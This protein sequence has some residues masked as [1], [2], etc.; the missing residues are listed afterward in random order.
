MADTYTSNLNMTKP[1]VGAS[2]DTWGTKWN[3]NLDTIDQQFTAAALA[4]KA[5]TPAADAI[6]YFTSGSAASV[7]TSH[8][9]GRAFAA[10]AS[11]AAARTYL[12]LAAVAASGSATDLTTGTLADARLP[13]IMSAKQFTD[14]ILIAGAAPLARLYESDQ[15]ADAKYWDAIAQGGQFILRTVNDALSSA[16]SFMTATRSGTTITDISFAA[17][18]LRFN[19]NAIYH[20][21]NLNPALYAPL[22]GA[23]FTG[24]VTMA[25]GLQ[26]TAGNFQ[27]GTSDGVF[28]RPDGS[29]EVSR[30]GGAYIDLKDAPGDDFD[31]RLLGSNAGLAVSAAATTFSGS[32][33]T[34]VAFLNVSTAPYNGEQETDAAAD[35][36]RWDEYVDGGTR[37]RR[38]LNDAQNSAYTFE[39]IVRS[40]V[41]ITGITWA[42]AGTIDFSTVSTFRHNGNTIWTA[43]NDGAGSG[44]DADTL[45]G[46]DSSLFARKSEGPNFTTAVPT[47]ESNPLKYA[48][49]A[50]D[51]VG[52]HALLACTTGGARGVNDTVAGSNLEWAHAGGAVSGNPSG[53]W[54]LLGKTSAVNQPALWERIA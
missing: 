30:A 31:V 7:F 42:S 46:Y 49:Q 3:T 18:A 44:L 1:E 21:G 10:L 43:G 54:R 26:I 19:G 24:A 41:S 20:A 4:L 23:A 27:I 45:D 52:Q 33:Q 22:A 40:G 34:N 25:N 29:I 51:T 5:V 2:R 11:A 28:A 47:Y 35:N 38:V 9:W 53:T 15:G 16:T 13:A 8:A 48:G 6:P 14:Q 32:V 17:T 50:A 39:T 37:R 36:Q 12:G